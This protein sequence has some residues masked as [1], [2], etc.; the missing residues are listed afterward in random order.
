MTRP[1]CEKCNLHPAECECPQEIEPASDEEFCISDTMWWE[2]RTAPVRQS[3]SEKAKLER[4]VRVRITQEREAREAAQDELLKAHGTIMSLEEE[5]E[6]ETCK[7][8]TKLRAAEQRAA[9]LEALLRNV[10]GQ[11]GGDALKAKIAA[12]LSEKGE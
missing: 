5:V 1:Q 9:K 6:V 4:F 11:Y 10:S 12:L 7:L 8:A 3:K 2:I